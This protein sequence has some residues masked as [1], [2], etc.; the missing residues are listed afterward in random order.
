MSAG[1]RL[2]LSIFCLALGDTRK[3]PAWSA[4]RPAGGRGTPE[5]QLARAGVDTFLKCAQSGPYTLGEQE[6][7]IAAP[8]ASRRPRTSALRFTSTA[9]PPRSFSERTETEQALREEN[10]TLP[11]VR[12]CRSRRSAPVIS[13]ETHSLE[14][15]LKVR[16]CLVFEEIRPTARSIF[17]ATSAPLVKKTPE[18]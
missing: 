1:G 15:F 10:V 2:K 18:G 7:E 14:R 17:P 8:P 6:M 12:F 3:S 5:S 11:L 4:A 16:G 9:S 13:E